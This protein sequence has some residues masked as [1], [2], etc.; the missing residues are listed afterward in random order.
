MLGAAGRMGK[1]VVEA[2]TEA[3][4]MEFVGGVGRG[5]DLVTAIRATHPTVLVDFTVPEAVLDNIRVGLRAGIPLV[6]G[7]TGLSADQVRLVDEEA[8]RR[9]LGVVI[10][11]NFALGAIL[12]MRFAREAAR[13]FP[14]AEIIELHHE[15]KHEAPSGTAMRTAELIGATRDTPSV[16]PGS[17]LELVDGAR[18]GAHAGVPI[19]S[20]RLPGHVAHQ[21]VIF[22]LP[23]ETL[24]IRHDLVDRRSFMP[25]VLLAVRHVAQLRGVH[26]LEELLFPAHQSQPSV[27]RPR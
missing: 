13:Y 3:S 7:T 27:S 23:G 1:A 14:N 25:G 16:G 9:E 10:A 6:V 12:M 15:N 4:D 20:V 21:E 5:D 26:G 22:G 19:H 2:V 18:G 11:P 8:R 24:C 17:K